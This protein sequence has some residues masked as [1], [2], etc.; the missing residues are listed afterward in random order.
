M[1]Y[2]TTS[3]TLFTGSKGITPRKDFIENIHSLFVDTFRCPTGLKLGI[4]YEP[5]CMVKNS[6]QAEVTS[7]ACML[8]N[9]SRIAEKFAVIA[10]KFD[11]IYAKRAFVHW[12]VGHGRAQHISKVLFKISYG[13]YVIVCDTNH[14]R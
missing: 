5:P 13:R 2:V 9:T 14:I 12:F 8:M 1:Y 3:F 11:Y 10:N 7:A 6:D 4:N